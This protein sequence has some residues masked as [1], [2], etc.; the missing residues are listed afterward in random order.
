MPAIL[1]SIEVNWMRRCAAQCLNRPALREAAVVLAVATLVF[2]TRLGSPALWDEDEP[3]NAACAREMLDRGDWLVPT[4]NDELRTDKPI[5]IYW[6][7]QFAYRVFGVNEFGARFWS[8]ALSVA[9]CLLT[10]RLGRRLYGPGV[11]LCAGA[12]L[13]TSLL[14]GVSARAATTDATLIFCTTLALTTFASAAIRPAAVAA[15]F[16]QFEPGDRRVFGLFNISVPK[17]AFVY[18]ALG[19]A[20]LAKGPTGYLLPA[21]IML[22]TM[23]RPVPGSQTALTLIAPNPC[24]RQRLWHFAGA[25]LARCRSALA[26]PATVIGSLLRG[27]RDSR[28]VMGTA[29]TL[30]VAVPWYVLVGIATNG[31]WPLGF[32]LRH[33]VERYLSP[34]EGHGGPLIYYPAALLI[35][36]LPW[37]WPGLVGLIEA[38]RRRMQTVV[39]GEAD[40]FLLVWVGAYL[41]FFSFSRTK[42]PSYVLPCFP[43]VAILAG[44]SLSAWLQPGATVSLRTRR[45]TL[46]GITLVGLAILVATPIAARRAFPDA[47][48]L[49]WV[50]LVPLLGGLAATWLSERGNLRGA[51]AAYG[52]TAALFLTTLFAFVADRIAAGQVS[53][54][55]VAALQSRGLNS[56]PIGEFGHFKPGLVFYAAKRVEVLWH[57]L[58]VGQ[59]LRRFPDARLMT[60]IDLLP[61]LAGELPPQFVVLDRRPAFL[62]PDREIVVL[63]RAPTVNPATRSEIQPQVRFADRASSTASSDTAQ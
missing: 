21:G 7:T 28:L 38:V 57:P 58:F 54:P 36:I 16:P 30:L 61:D 59:F 52:A 17:A 47:V 14:F 56:G 20:V 40:R 46:G 63:G 11:G 13:A 18:A 1:L 44:R 24:L 6:L 42:L 43:A 53:R 29:V 49:A 12:I 34:M 23:W 60:R 8:A 9:T 45:F 15:P 48:S 37:S 25:A 35:G 31:K 41:A 2:F 19:L 55:A 4:F 5:L 33:N 27:I 26:A 22:L 3:K 50:G 62:R 39:G 10:W 51:L 32:L